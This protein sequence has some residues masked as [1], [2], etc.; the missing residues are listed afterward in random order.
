M[1]NT[2]KFTISMPAGEFKALEA[3]RRKAGK[4]RSQFVREAV[5]AWESA[6][7]E[8]PAEIPK[9]AAAVKEDSARYGAPG[10]ALPELTD[11]TERRR[12]AIAAAG[13]FRSGVAD[14]SSAHDSYF[15]DGFAA[16]EESRPASGPDSEENS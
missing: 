15:E 4:T 10:P 8:R 3:T 14:L 1:G 13:R 7:G 6:E 9:A 2:I 16:V 12:R 5:R 11:S